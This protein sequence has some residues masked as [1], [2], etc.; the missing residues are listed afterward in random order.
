MPI[1]SR[2]LLLTAAGVLT[3]CATAQENPHY[4]YSTKYKG[5]APSTAYASNT[6]VITQQQ[7]T[8]QSASYQQAPATAPLSYTRNA[9]QTG[10]ANSVTI[11]NVGTQTIAATHTASHPSISGQS[12][13]GQSVSGQAHSSHGATHTAAYQA[14]A[15]HSNAA[16]APIYSRISATCVASGQQGTLDCTPQTISIGT[17]TAQV[18]Q[19]Y[20]NLQI[21]GADVITAA[22]TANASASGYSS[23]QY[24]AS[25]RPDQDIQGTPGYEAMKN[26]QTSWSQSENISAPAGAAVVSART[27]DMQPSPQQSYALGR[28]HVV[29]KGDTVYSFS[30]KLCSSIE[31]IKEMNGLDANFGLQIGQTI[32]LPASNC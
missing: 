25:Q 26:A 31:D 22:N 19:P 9:P 6:A 23:R 16:G 2:A 5:D 14:P 17:Q 21:T 1:L 27:M 15:Q 29:S 11:H 10:A 12:I 18:S 32:R 20:Q 24:S 28:S 13:S 7:G 30:R 4:K 8:L 3:A